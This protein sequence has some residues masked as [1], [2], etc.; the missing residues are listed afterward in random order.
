MW[1]S[2]NLILCSG[3][4]GAKLLVL[5]LLVSSS[6][7]M[8]V[9]VLPLLTLPAALLTLPLALSKCMLVPSLTSRVLPRPYEAD[10]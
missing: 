3:T 7:P 9:P 6:A 1:N 5:L 10:E 2:S 8:V 4:L